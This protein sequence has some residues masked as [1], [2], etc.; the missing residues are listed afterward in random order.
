MDTT[1]RIRGDGVDTVRL[2]H[3]IGGAGD[4][5]GGED[6]DPTKQCLLPKDDGAEEGRFR[7]QGEHGIAAPRW[8]LGD[9]TPVENLGR[10]VGR[11]GNW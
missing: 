6:P 10:E 9:G 1:Q 11:K 4:Q 7:G 5:A 2:G 8:H 3:R